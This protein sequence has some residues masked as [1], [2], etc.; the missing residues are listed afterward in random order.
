[1]IKPMFWE[2]LRLNEKAECFPTSRI[3]GC[4][5][6]IPE[7]KAYLLF[8]GE[9]NTIVHHLNQLQ[10]R[11]NPMKGAKDSFNTSLAS[12]KKLSLPEIV[13]G[14][15]DKIFFYNIGSTCSINVETNKWSMEVTKGKLPEFRTF[16]AYYYNGKIQTKQ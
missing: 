12:A 10:S 1:M 15:N 7:R 2:Q 9:N 8:G 14:K 11:Q 13:T 16:F 5:I 3:G 4:F 6:Y